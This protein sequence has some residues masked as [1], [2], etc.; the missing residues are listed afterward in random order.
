MNKPGQ[1]A[2]DQQRYRCVVS[3][4][5]GCGRTYTDLTGATFRGM[6]RGDPCGQFKVTVSKEYQSFNKLHESEEVPINRRTSWR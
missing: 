5:N 1:D 2:H 4:E 6:M 3:D